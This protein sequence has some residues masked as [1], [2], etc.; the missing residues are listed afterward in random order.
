MPSVCKVC[1][2]LGLLLAMPVAGMACGRTLHDH[3]PSP[4]PLQ[5]T[6][7]AAGCV[8][9]APHPTPDLPSG[10]LF[11]PLSR[12]VPTPATLPVSCPPTAIFHP[13]ETQA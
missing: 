11:L 4:V 2:I 9:S 6:H 1:V 7:A 8:F 3:G 5:A 10:E 12:I 13:P